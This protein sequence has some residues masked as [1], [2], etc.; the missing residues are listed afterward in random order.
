[1]DDTPKYITEK[2]HALLEKKSYTERYQMSWSMYLTSRF[3]V[4]RGIKEEHPEYTDI[5]LRKELFLRF[6]GDDFNEEQ[7]KKIL[8]HLSKT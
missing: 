3:L 2:L 6:Y 4:L 8:A 5:D 1:M 7:K